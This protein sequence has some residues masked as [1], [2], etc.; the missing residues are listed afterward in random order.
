MCQSLAKVESAQGTEDGCGN[1]EDIRGHRHGREER[2]G[3]EHKTI[4]GAKKHECPD[5]SDKDASAQ[6]HPEYR[7][8]FSTNR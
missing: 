7:P 3:V 4:H 5:D 2:P 1:Q 8:I 6:E